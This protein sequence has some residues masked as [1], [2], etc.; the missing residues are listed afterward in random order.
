M[1]VCIYLSIYRYGCIIGERTNSHCRIL[2]R[3]MVKTL[4]T[5][6]WG[7]PR[8]L[9]I[10]S[11]FARSLHKK[12]KTERE[13]GGEMRGWSKRCVFHSHHPY[14]FWIYIEKEVCIYI[15]IYIYVM[16]MQIYIYTHMIYIFIYTHMIYIPIS[17][18]FPSM[19]E[20]EMS[21]SKRKLMVK[22][23]CHSHRKTRTDKGFVSPESKDSAYRGDGSCYFWSW[24]PN[25]ETLFIFTFECPLQ[26]SLPCCRAL[27][28]IFKSQR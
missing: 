11:S 25:T 28:W 20:S 17:T 1:Y 10:A 2:A 18:Y 13:G 14:R 22:N 3:C 24:Y 23:T 21:T 16:Y 15:Y 7:T 8:S 27:I 12:E 19:S 4:N 26:I 9:R 6:S 5:S